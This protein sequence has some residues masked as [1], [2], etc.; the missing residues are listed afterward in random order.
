MFGVSL[1][2][3]SSRNPASADSISY[4]RV[5][6]HPDGEALAPFCAVHAVPVS[7]AQVHL[8]RATQI[9]A[10]TYHIVRSVILISSRPAG[11]NHSNPS[12]PFGDRAK[13]RVSRKS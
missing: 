4:Q 9:Q 3:W 6:S 13:S 2:S 8:G 12:N 10:Q 11:P 1:L 5:H 7:L